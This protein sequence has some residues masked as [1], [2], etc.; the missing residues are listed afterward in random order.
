MKIHHLLGEP[1]II[2]TNEERDFINH[3]GNEIRINALK[4]REQVLAHN[5]V[6]K[7]VYSISNNSQ[8]LHLKDDQDSKKFN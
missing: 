3:M 6:R 7:G 4:E 2:L 5:L 8:T 1:S